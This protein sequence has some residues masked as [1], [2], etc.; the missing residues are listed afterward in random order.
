MIHWS[1]KYVGI[2]FGEGPGE[3]NCWG[4]V[5]LVYR[6]QLGKELPSYG[7]ISAKDLVLAARTMDAVKDDGWRTVEPDEFAV[8]IMYGPTHRN[9]ICHVGV[10]VSPTHL[11][12][13]EDRT[14]SVLIPIKHPSVCHRI[15]GFRRY[16][17]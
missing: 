9:R 3:R 4:L 6:E 15:A 17:R 14:A 8:C 7:E 16:E 5:R 1:N 11:L 10:M 13:T 2:P 12:H